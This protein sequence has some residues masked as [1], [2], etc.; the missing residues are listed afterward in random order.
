MKPNFICLG[1]A[2]CG[3]TTLSELLRQHRD[4]YMP[5]IKEPLFFSED[6]FYKK[7]E[8]W[9][10]ER[11]Y[12]GVKDQK[13][14]GEVNPLL[15]FFGHSGRICRYFDKDTKIIFMM[16][17]PVEKAYSFFKMFLRN[18]ILQSEITLSK[19]FDLKKSFEK[20]VLRNCASGRAVKNMVISQGEYYS[21]MAPYLKHFDKKNIKFIIFEEMI[22]NPQ[23]TFREVEDFLGLKHA[24]YIDFNVET[25]EGYEVP[26]NQYYV[27]LRRKL[28]LFFYWIIRHTTAKADPWILFV[29]GDILNITFPTQRVSKY[30]HK[31]RDMLHLPKKKVKKIPMTQRTRKLLEDYYR[32]DKKKVE[33]L[34]GRSLDDLWFK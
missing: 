10:E 8:A 12:S 16:R 6:E 13:A 1:F 31:L 30:K 7:G 15:T 24:D 21:V 4:V 2:K 27:V 14:V 5:E 33:K 25:N 22:A 29:F 28:K 19:Q 17:S 3:T 20:Y 11:Y 26:Q 9:Y 34:L 18:G 32:E 23:K